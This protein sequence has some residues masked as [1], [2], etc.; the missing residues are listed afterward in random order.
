M[1]FPPF[2]KVLGFIC[3]VLG[4]LGFV[5][6]KISL[7]FNEQ[8]LCLLQLSAWNAFVI[9]AAHWSSMFSQILLIKSVMEPVQ[10]ITTIQR[11][12]THG[13]KIYDTVRSYMILCWWPKSPEYHRKRTVV[14]WCYKDPVVWGY[15]WFNKITSFE[16]EI[17][18][19]KSYSVLKG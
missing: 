5:S 17:K 13:E 7:L 18:S 6:N 4:S 11:W 8:E 19:S 2:W 1:D 9:L 16:L 10:L 15:L 14:L 3:Y 12:L